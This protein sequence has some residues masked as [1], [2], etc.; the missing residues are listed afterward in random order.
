[1]CNVTMNRLLWKE[2]MREADGAVPLMNDGLPYLSVPQFN[3]VGIF[4]GNPSTTSRPVLNNLI[5]N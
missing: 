3:G 1:M 2:L 4:K 5:S